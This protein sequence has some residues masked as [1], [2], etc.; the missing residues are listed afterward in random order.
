MFRSSI[1]L[2]NTDP[3]LAS[4]A[5]LNGTGYEIIQTNGQR[6]YQRPNDNKKPKKG[7]EIFVGKLP[8]DLYEDELV[9]LFGGIGPIHQ[10][11]L[12][13]DFT[14]QNRGFCFISYYTPVHA[15]TAVSI[16]NGFEIRPKR[17]IGVYKSIDNC[18]LFV[19]GI[20]VDKTR[21]EVW[22]CLKRYVDGIVDVI[23]YPS[24]ENRN[25]NRGY[26]F[27]EFESHRHATMA[28]RNLSP[29]SLILWDVPILVD[30]AE[31]IPEVDPEVMSQVIYVPTFL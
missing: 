21:E 24:R 6:V 3:Y 9:P 30:W 4:L 19:G 10:L 17:R 1:M 20:P 28:R 25:Q 26:A 22:Q 8:R 11:R 14:G 16:L 7:S 31:P 18:R 23:M 29:G 27:L 15:N 12:M 2:E 5:L 13:M